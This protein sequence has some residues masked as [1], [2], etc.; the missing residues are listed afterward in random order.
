MLIYTYNNRSNNL[1]ERSAIAIAE[2]FS[3]IPGLKKLILN[4]SY[5]YS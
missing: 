3:Q 4:L 2:S 5:C 1:S